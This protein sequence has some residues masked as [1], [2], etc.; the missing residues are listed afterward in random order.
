M[1]PSLTAARHA[2]PWLKAPTQLPAGYQLE[3]AIVGPDTVWLRYA[4][5]SNRFS[6][7][8][9]KAEEGEVGP[10]SMEGGWFWKRGGLRYF[11]TGAPSGSVPNM[12]SSLQ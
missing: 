9:Q 1:Y 10:Q 5:S 12:Y 11:A 7:F 6:L 3:S 2:A 4:T 8:I